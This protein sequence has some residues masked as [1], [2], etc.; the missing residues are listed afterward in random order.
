MESRR[1][2]DP[3]LGLFIY[4]IISKSNHTI[5]EVADFLD[6]DERTVNYYCTGERRPNQIRLLKLLKF[7][8]VDSQS[9]PF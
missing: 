8:E 2:T 5:V 1:K 7:L 6:I 9:I 4:S 3:E